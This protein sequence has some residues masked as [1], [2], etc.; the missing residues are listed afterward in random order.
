MINSTTILPYTESAMLIQVGSIPSLVTPLINA[1]N[2]VTCDGET[3]LITLPVVWTVSSVINR[4]G[5]AVFVI[6]ALLTLSAFAFIFYHRR[7]SAVR[8]TSPTFFCLSLVGVLTLMASML[9]VTRPTPDS[10]LCSAL[11]WTAQLG[12]TLLFAPL[13][14]K[15]YR[16]Y[17]IFG[18]KKLKV[19]KITNTSLLQGL[20][21]IVLLDV[22]YLSVW[23]G[24]APMSSV[25]TMQLESDQREHSYQQCSFSA[26]DT[27]T[28]FFVASV[29]IKAAWLC[30]G[31]LLAFSTRSVTDQFN[32]SKS[33]ALAIYNVVFA[34]GLIAPLTA[35]I[36]AQGDV[37]VILLLFCLLWV[38]YFTL[39]LLAFPKVLELLSSGHTRSKS[40]SVQ[41]DDTQDTQY[42]FLP[43][44][45]LT[46]QHAVHQYL[47]ALE[48]HVTN[49]RTHLAAIK[50]V[51][52]P[53]RHSLASHNSR[54]SALS[55]SGKEGMRNSPLPK[56]P[57]LSPMGEKG[58]GGRTASMSAVPIVSRGEPKSP[59]LMSASSQSQA[60]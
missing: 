52:S 28:H 39:G 32:E 4:L 21:A 45:H 3:L 15:A 7:N 33:I 56:S 29:V 2:S 23:Q 8:S 40:N 58:K 14:L 34:V 49:T 54:S 35:L 47:H 13:F 60:E 25:I 24:V 57:V 19:V 12:F 10:P 36:A 38:S 11:N 50:G 18:G 20:A 51:K 9:I 16:I 53:E 1:L 31:V 48:K 44:D 55:P 59:A 37:R 41:P 26:T 22:I 5:I 17:R 30:V 43:L 6:G 42:D 27:S 46:S